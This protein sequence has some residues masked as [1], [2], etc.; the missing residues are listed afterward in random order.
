[1]ADGG[2]AMGWGHAGRAGGDLA[3]LH[4]QQYCD[5]VAHAAQTL[6]AA[7]QNLTHQA[8][9]HVVLT[10]PLADSDALKFQPGAGLSCSA[11]FL[12][13]MVRIGVMSGGSS[14]R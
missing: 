9:M 3:V 13:R 1:M 10:G 6:L 14:D 5:V 4:A 2:L 11:K 8:V 12:H 7:S